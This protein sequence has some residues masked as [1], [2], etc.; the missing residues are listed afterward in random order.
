[1]ILS[2]ECDYS[3]RI[4]RVLADGN[5]KAVK[6][7]CGEENI[8][9]PYTYKLLKKLEH[10]GFVKSIRGR[11]GGYMLAR[12]LDSFTM[13]DVLFAINPNLFFLECLKEGHNNCPQQ[14]KGGKECRYHA[15]FLHM[16]KVFEDEMRRKTMKEILEAALP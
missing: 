1:M 6:T 11:E 9:N 2:R 5:K 14:K 4:I 10:S 16:Q 15:A 12:D 7:I 13:Y 8:P 3:L